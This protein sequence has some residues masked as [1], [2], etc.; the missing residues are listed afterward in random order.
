MRKLSEM[1]ILCS[2]ILA[3]TSF[4]AE[5]D[6]L[7]L[8]TVQGDAVISVPPDKVK[9]TLGLESRED[10]LD[11]AKYRVDSLMSVVKSLAGELGIPEKNLRT[12]QYLVLPANPKRTKHMVKATVVA[13]ITDLTVFNQF[14]S[15][16]IDVGVDE[17]RDVSF[18]L[19][20]PL[21]VRIQARE[22]AAEAARRKAEAILKTLG[23]GL[24]KVNSVVDIQVDDYLATS[25]R[26]SYNAYTMRER[27]VLSDESEPAIAVG[28]IEE[29][30]SV[31]VSFEI[32]Q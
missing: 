8:I 29:H 25:G 1:V 10:K 19:T 13:T 15:R 7:R 6:S 5:C 14:L 32:A 18:Q 9:I 3:S 27:P 4:G 2:I 28:Q 16:A 30:A 31:R 21:A 23:A 24:G 26:A 11:K 20:D 17:I 22:Q 12:E